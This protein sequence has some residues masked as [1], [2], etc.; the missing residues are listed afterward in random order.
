MDRFLAPHTPEAIAYT[1]LTENWFNWDA[2]HPS[3][4]ETLISGCASYQAFN[5][6]LAGL[7]IYLVPEN[8]PQLERV[9]RRYSYDAI[10]NAISK[11]R[12]S[13]ERGG[14]SRICHLAEKSIS[15]VLDTGDNVSYLLALHNPVSD[16]GKHDLECTSPHPI[17]T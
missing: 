10:H 15:N 4:N 7:D 13:L 14:Y 12:S 9:L 8:R 16:G 1:H 3:L 5:R 17:T 6:Y 2:E 11:A